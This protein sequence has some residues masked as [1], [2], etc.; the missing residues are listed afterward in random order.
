MTTPSTDQILAEVLRRQ[1][2]LPAWGIPETLLAAYYE[3]P[4]TVD[5]IQHLSA[6]DALAIYRR[7]YI[8]AAGLDSLTG[9]LAVLMMDFAIDA[10]PRVAIKA[11]QKTAHAPVVDGILSVLTLKAMRQYTDRELYM[12][13]LRQ[14]GLYLARRL[15][16][17]PEL[18]MY[19]PLFLIRLMEF[20]K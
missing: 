15:Q 13:V 16:L 8:E 17:N 1:A 5:D 3:R 12:G 9:E 18:R 11:L 20:V 6:E 14:R 4:I 2:H 10:G 19:A 7:L